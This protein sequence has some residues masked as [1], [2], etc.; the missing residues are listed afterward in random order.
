MKNKI[1]FFYI[2]IIFLSLLFSFFLKIDISNGGSSGDLSYHWKY[3]LALNDNLK[4]LLE[5][6]HQHKYG[7]PFHFPLH[8]III[9]R[10]DYLVSN[11]ENYI[12]FYFVISLFLPCL[13]YLCLQ[14]R[15]PEIQTS[16]KIFLASIIYFL[17]KLPGISNMGKLAYYKFI[18][19]YRFII[20]FNYFRKKQK[21]EYKFKYFF[22][23]TFYGVCCLYKT[24]LCYLFPIFICHY[25]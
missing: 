24:I 2:S 8:H 14:N 21:H 4:I 7:Y 15:F 5:T 13:F 10:F 6:D 3:I 25:Y 17:P 22:Y 18:F 19:F 1:Q 12:N 11:L 16:K 23:G 20:F 9:S